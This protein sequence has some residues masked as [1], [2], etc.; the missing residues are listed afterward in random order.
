MT[1]TQAPKATVSPTQPPGNPRE[2]PR[3]PGPTP[4]A[5]VSSFAEL[6]ADPP[7]FM[8]KLA[9]T[10]GPV[11]R[12]NLGV[13]RLIYVNDPELIQEILVGRAAD[14]VKDSITQK[15]NETLGN[16]LLTSEGAFWRRQRKLMAPLF[17]RKTLESYASVMVDRTDRWLATMGDGE[18]RDVHADMMRLTLDIIVGTVF[19]MELDLDATRVGHAIDLMMDQF[20]KELRTWRRF[21]PQSWLLG[22][23][24]KTAEARATLDGVVYPLIRKRR[25]ALQA[26]GESDDIVTRLLAARGEDGTAMSDQQVRDEAVTMF[27]AGH[28]TTALVLTF[29]A[30]L[31]AR[32]PEVADRLREEAQSALG[33]RSPTMAD[34]AQLPLAR[35]VVLETMRLYP[36]AYIIGRKS[37]VPINLG[38]F[39][40][41]AGEQMLMVQWVMHRDARW[42]VEPTEFRPERWLDGLEERLPRGVYFPFGGGPRICIGQHFAMMEAT[43][44]LVTMVRRV[45][46]TLDAGY[47]LELSPAVTLR[48]RGGLRMKVKR[49]G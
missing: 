22:G 24:A 48:P 38:G 37:M 5:V 14:L 7:E 31:L 15:L 23:R 49:L 17:K 32:R 26:G 16:G 11:V 39:R 42:F 35:A 30:L 9:R 29:A 27:V 6:R 44:C 43:L 1:A 46:W 20:E 18:E 41:D 2:L 40:V 8:A 19:G 33:E 34:M 47:Q 13:E 36:P 45:G 12:V 25:E 21:V 3:P 4:W 10:Y 28:E